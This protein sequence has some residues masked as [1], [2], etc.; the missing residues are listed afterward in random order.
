MI[1][2]RRLNF[3]ESLRRKAFHSVR[4]KG[5]WRLVRPHG[6]ARDEAS[7]LAGDDTKAWN[8]GDG[9]CEE[10]SAARDEHHG[11]NRK[12]GT[13][14]SP[15]PPSLPSS[16]ARPMRLTILPLP[17]ALK[18]SMFTPSRSRYRAS[19]SL[20][21]ATSLA[22]IFLN[23]RTQRILEGC[24]RARIRKSRDLR[25]VSH[26]AGKPQTRTLSDALDHSNRVRRVF[27][28][29][30]AMTPSAVRDRVGMTYR[31]QHKH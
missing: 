15:S 2:E 11:N 7:A 9:K 13:A 25:L 6:T 29:E 27:S 3:A 4:K 24:E 17:P 14:T 19:A 26:D 28:A 8:T 31:H 16:K 10:E 18:K 22:E 30:S 21:R 20:R 1:C 23:K 5:A 12:D